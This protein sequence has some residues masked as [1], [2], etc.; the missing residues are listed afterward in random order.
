MMSFVMMMMMI[1]TFVASSTP[2]IKG[3]LSLTAAAKKQASKQ[4]SKACRHGS[5]RV[6]VSEAK[7]TARQPDRPADLLAG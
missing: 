3:G 1:E 2:D 5:E 4:V 7:K 6:N